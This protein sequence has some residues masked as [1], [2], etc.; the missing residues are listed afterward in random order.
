MPS[1]R[2]SLT[3][4]TA[5]DAEVVLPGSKS[6]T[7]RGL[8]LAAL[9]AGESHLRGALVAEDASV[10]RA[11]L[12]ELG[13][14]V[15]ELGPAPGG[16][17]LA[18][19]GV[20]GRWTPERAEL[21]VRLSGTAL[22]F[23]TAA[24]CLGRG[25]FRLDGNARMRE[26]PVEDQLEAL[27]S[28]GVDARSELGTGCPPVVVNADGLP[29]GRVSVSGE[30]SSQYL[31]G[32][33]MAA[34]YARSPLTI[35]VAGELQS[36]P[37]VD[38][39]L[40]LMEEFGARV[41]REDYRRFHVPAGRYE[42]RE[43][44]IEGDAMAAGYFWAMAAM[45]G[46]SVT[47]LGVGANSVQGDMAL[48]EVLE[49][50]GCEVTVGACEVRV[51]GPHGG[52]LSGG[53][54]DLNGFPDQAQTLAVLA[55]AA[56]APVH[57]DNVWNLRIKETDRLRAL[58]IELRR[59]GAEVEERPDGLTVW[60][61]AGAPRPGVIATYGDHRMAMAFAL[62]GA[63]WPGL[64]IDDPAC[65]DKTYPRFWSDLARAGVGVEASQ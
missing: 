37:F 48:L 49:S 31:S 54:F 30:R 22:R 27:R 43:H 3:P 65:V 33:L 9:A 53:R 11:A 20:A 50:M 24:V 5:F 13:S 12:Q 4:P 34:P 18:V 38:M 64:V 21:D 17:D 16:V 42:A 32:L 35:D 1:G 57:V 6:L 41:E 39:T 52:S 40:G 2:V 8:L 51:V 7:N 36:K 29:G 44:R 59:L 46:G 58:A 56:Q 61:L 19:T 60:P 45:T 23:L 26:R 62:A 10:M 55:L 28:L 25:R 14:E 15:R 63:R 47:T